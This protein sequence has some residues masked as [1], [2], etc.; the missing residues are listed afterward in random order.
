MDQ[1]EALAGWNSPLPVDKLSLT[2]AWGVVCSEGQR[3]GERERTN[4]QVTLERGMEGGRREWHIQ[5]TNTVT[6]SLTKVAHKRRGTTV[7]TGTQ[8]SHTC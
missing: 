2:Q 4:T 8:S 5:H 6:Q 7:L 3:E 1:R